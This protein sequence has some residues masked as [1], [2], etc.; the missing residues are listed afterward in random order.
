MMMARPL[1]HEASSSSY[2][3]LSAM[4]IKTTRKKRFE[5]YA[6]DESNPTKTL[7]TFEPRL[8]GGNCSLARTDSWKSVIC[9]SASP[10]PQTIG[11]VGVEDEVRVVSSSAEGNRGKCR[12]VIEPTSCKKNGLNFWLSFQY[13]R[14]TLNYV[15]FNI[16]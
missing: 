12:Y 7:V 16:F 4:K 6:R 15:R 14:K 9:S 2:Y 1:I 3:L 10:S 13:D 8:I 11:R 5:K